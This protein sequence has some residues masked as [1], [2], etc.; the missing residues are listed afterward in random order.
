MRLTF[1]T[2][3]LHLLGDL[4][5]TDAGFDYDP[6][7]PAQ[8]RRVRRTLKVRL[9]TDLPTTVDY[10]AHRAKVMAALT[11]ILAAPAGTL[12]W[13]DDQAQNT[14][15]NRPALLAGSNLPENPNELGAF[16]Q[17]VEF[18]FQ[19]EE[20]VSATPLTSSFTPTGGSA[21]TLGRVTTYH[22]SDTIT[23]PS[24]LR[25]LRERVA[26]KVSLSGKVDA[27]PTLAL[28]DRQAALA[29]AKLALDTAF[30]AR[31]GTLVHGAFCNR[32]VRPVA[33][34][35]VVNQAE[36]CVE[37]TLDAEF[38]RFPDESGYLLCDFTVKT[39]EDKEG[40]TIDRTFSGTIGAHTEIAA[41]AKVDL[42]LTTIGSGYQVL[43]YD[44]D[45]QTFESP[46]GSE[47]I[48]MPFSVTLRK[49]SGGIVNEKCSFED[50][51]DTASGFI[52]RTY[53][54]TVTAKAST[55]DGAYSVA[56][57]RAEVLSAGKHQF[58]VR[59]R[60]SV[61]DNQQRAN[62]VTSGDYLVTVS[63]SHEY[64]LRAERAL[65]EWSAEENKP[66][67]GEFGLAVAGSVVAKTEA[68][69]RA[70]YALI[71]ALYTAGTL[72]DERVT[73]RQE[74]IQD[75]GSVAVGSTWLPVPAGNWA[76]GLTGGQFNDVNTGESAS[77]VTGFTQQHVRLEFSF[78]Q[79]LPRASGADLA[80]RYELRTELDYLRLTK[81]SSLQG[82]VFAS[83][84][85]DCTWV[86]E[87]VLAGFT[88]LGSL[89][90]DARGE[91]REK[92]YGV[93]GTT[94]DDVPQGTALH[95]TTGEAYTGTLTGYTFSL[96]YEGRLT[97]VSGVL[98]CRL[99]ESLKH[100]GFNTV[101]QPTAFG[102][103]KF[104]DCGY[105]HAVR[106]IEGSVTA[107][108]ESACRS[109]MH[110]A[111]ATTLLE[112]ATGETRALPPEINTEW[113]IEPR[114]ELVARGGGANARVVRISFRREFLYE[115][116]DYTAP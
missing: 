74:A 113:D 51:E 26:G 48:R 85:T 77:G 11:A 68:T 107:A 70:H 41:V 47:F 23:R 99:T 6:P 3:E 88:G 19:W 53:Q 32:V 106:Q 102:R 112:A 18:T 79:Q 59:R 98:E 28:A 73:A 61:S 52:Q 116:L 104:Q 100:S 96:E 72:R 60:Y 42:L 82:E 16:E 12:L 58:Q 24:E 40:G 114:T 76:A 71:K 57:Q 56:T 1:G 101:V 69:A 103:P 25:S 62:R 22:E 4:L 38:T 10:A 15:V 33:R 66:R 110:T 63:F 78:T 97:G 21:V 31:T 111:L 86:V 13:T 95:V 91:R 27:S 80:V 46:D 83:L 2:V 65:C 115:Q 44:T 7:P 49:L 75:M 64:R 36:W 30:T 50:A 29:T 81:R 94:A 43:S 20:A 54:G 92:F 109:W 90:R 37:W 5:V 93:R 17:A 67:F 108:T 84:L 55:W 89:V 8:P 39:R 14:F 35:V 34:N 105:T 87:Q 45:P 9:E